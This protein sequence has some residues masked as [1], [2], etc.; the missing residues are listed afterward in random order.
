[1]ERLDSKTG[2]QVKEIKGPFQPPKVQQ[3][4]LHL[5]LQQLFGKGH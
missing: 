3:R 4:I 2:G 5:F 1:M